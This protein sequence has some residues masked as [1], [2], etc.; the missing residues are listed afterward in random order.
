MFTKAIQI[1]D[2]D[3]K[4]FKMS[5]MKEEIEL[6]TKQQASAFASISE[7]YMTELCDEENAEEQCETNIH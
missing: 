7:L 6:A 4:M 1:L 5:G 2:N 3:I